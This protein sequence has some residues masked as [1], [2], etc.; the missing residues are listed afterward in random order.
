[1]KTQ[2]IISS[3][4]AGRKRGYVQHAL[5]IVVS[6]AICWYYLRDIHWSDLLSSLESADLGLALVGAF[7][8]HLAWWIADARLNQRLVTWF[9]APL[10]FKGIFWV[11]GFAYLA[12]IINPVIGEGGILVYLYRRT[13]MTGRLFAGI[14]FFKSINMLVA[15]LFTVTVTTLLTYVSGV[16]L[17]DYVNVP[18]WWGGIAFGYFGLFHAWS[19]WI[20]G[21]SWG[22]LDKYLDRESEFFI[23]YARGTMKHW[24]VTWLYTIVPWVL[25]YVGYYLVA[26]A[27]DV[28][29]P[30][31]AFFAVAPL[32]LGL[33]FLPVFFGGFGSTTMMWEG[34]FP[35]SGAE[36]AVLALTLFIPFTRMIFRMLTGLVSL[37][38]VQ[39][40]LAYI[41]KGKAAGAVPDGDEQEKANG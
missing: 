10:D 36:S 9:H 37:F 32:A 17:S 35:G 22:F 2:D 23:P 12:M 5:A 14:L 27:F 6:L 19:Y 25:T 4:G 40:D 33:A 13:G 1:M 3:E 18:L 8:P 28:R 31:V 20:K 34:F 41:W 39:D 38:P 26:M 15:V 7:V 16:E 11:R 29:V 24:A 30:P 21:H